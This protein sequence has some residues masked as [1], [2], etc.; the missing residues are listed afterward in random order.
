MEEILNVTNMHM[1]ER[2][3]N[4]L[5]IRDSKFAPSR[6]VLSST[7]VSLRSKSD[8]RQIR[9]EIE[10]CAITSLEFVH[11]P[12]VEAACNLNHLKCGTLDINLVKN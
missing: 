10:R 3:K 2:E 5:H 11:S 9:T 12:K 8:A 6:K 1:R 4:C 7:S